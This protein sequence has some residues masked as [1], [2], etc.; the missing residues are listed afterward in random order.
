M[1]YYKQWDNVKSENNCVINLKIQVL[2]KDKK[3]LD[4]DSNDF[5]VK[6][7]KSKKKLKRNQ[8]SK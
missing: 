1:D 3:P 8:Q 5:D 7:K 2:G 6:N 4:I